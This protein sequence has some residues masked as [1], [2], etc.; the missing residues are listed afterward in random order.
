MGVESDGK[1]M[2]LSGTIGATK[3]VG[4]VLGMLLVDSLGRKPL[5]IGGSIGYDF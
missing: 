1:A 4:V 5:L 3:L 2:L